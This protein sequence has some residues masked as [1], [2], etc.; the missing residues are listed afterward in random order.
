[1]QSKFTKDYVTDIDSK[2]P[3]IIE[4][5]VSFYGERFRPEITTKLTNTRFVFVGSD[6][7]VIEH[8]NQNGYKNLNAAQ[9]ALEV[10]EKS[11]DR[12][13]KFDRAI[14]SKK[15]YITNIVNAIAMF[16]K[17]EKRG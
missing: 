2:I 3:Q 11:K 1:M 17:L 12:I 10:Q 6:Q 15:D 5:F 16:I 7:S 4:Y 8:I 13:K 14:K 9:Q